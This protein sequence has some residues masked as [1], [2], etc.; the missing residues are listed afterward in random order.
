MRTPLPSLK[1]KNE[2]FPCVETLEERCTPAATVSQVGNTVTITADPLLPNLIV[3]SDNGTSNTGAIKVSS[4]GMSVFSL[5]G[6][7]VTA[8][9]PI[10]VFILGSTQ[11]TTVVYNLVGNLTTDPGQLFP[12]QTGSG[13]RLIQAA[14]FAKNTD[15]FNFNWPFLGT[16]AGT[17][18]EA[19][20]GL[21][22]GAR[23]SLQASSTARTEFLS[24]N[25]NI[26][27]FKA[28]LFVGLTAGRGVDHVA[29]NENI[30]DLTGTSATFPG[31]SSPTV[32]NATVISSGQ[33][34]TGSQVVELPVLVSGF[35]AG[36][37]RLSDQN[38]GL[39]FGN[40]N[41]LATILPFVTPFGLK[42]SNVHVI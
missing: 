16:P 38:I 42:P 13:G 6:T 21:L 17:T 30:F 27:A 32:S 14:L 20:S 28:G 37:V 39:I 18:Q 4:N 9:Q 5:D 24:A 10:Q 29:V 33:A 34:K 31:S 36:G 11:D 23:F 35:T 41:E 40:G 22:D 1:R 25:L 15:A 2:F 8:A 12:G 26:D 3:I 19:F 7:K